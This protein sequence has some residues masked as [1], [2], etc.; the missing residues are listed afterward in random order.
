MGLGWA[1]FIDTPLD[2]FYCLTHMH[3]SAV[4]AVVRC[5]SVRLFVRQYTSVTLVLYCVETT[6]FIIKQL[7]Q[8]C[9]G[10]RK[11]GAT[12]SNCKYS[13]NSITELRGNW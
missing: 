6:K 9:I 10:W 1:P 4:Y 2:A 8:D 11:N 13:E 7:A 12:L 3:H 5:L